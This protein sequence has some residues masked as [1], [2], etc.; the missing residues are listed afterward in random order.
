MS[1]SIVT[2]GVILS[3][4][5]YQ[6]AD[7]IL[8]VLTP[9]QGRLSLIAKGVR[10]PKSKLAGGIEL[11]TINELTI[12]PSKGD[13]KTLIS[14]RMHTNFGNIVKDVKRTM[15]GYEVLKQLNRYME[16]EAG[17]EYFDLLVGVLEG[18][19]NEMLPQHFIELW[20]T[21][22]LLRITGHAP[23]L[24][25][26]TEGAK[27]SPDDKYVFDFDSAGFRDHPAG[28]YTANHI[29]LLRLAY[30]SESPLIFNQ[31]HDAD[32]FMPDVLSLTKNLLRQ[33]V[34]G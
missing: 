14:S 20:F 31:V 7:R 26:N 6:E 18:L 28:T 21:M 33:Y 5:D 3:R 1:A 32:L 2:K 22:Q 11:F 27:L 29:K 16:D 10:K 15:F 25:T 34:N 17:P 30:A 4:R 24:H 19:D 23:N 9:D 8:N 13:L 12:L